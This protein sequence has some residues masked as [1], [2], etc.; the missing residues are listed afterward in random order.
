MGRRYIALGLAVMLLLSFVSAQNEKEK[1]AEKPDE[2]PQVE[3]K[4]KGEESETY[5]K[6]TSYFIKE[7]LKELMKVDQMMNNKLLACQLLT[8]CKMKSEQ[9]FHRTVSDPNNRKL[10]PTSS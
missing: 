1:A 5:D 9:V 2:Q 8:T 6:N 10:S 3:D 7:G 4:Q